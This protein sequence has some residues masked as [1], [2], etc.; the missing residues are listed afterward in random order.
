MG[1]FLS[2]FRGGSD[3]SGD[4]RVSK[5]TCDLLDSSRLSIFSSGLDLVRVLAAR[6]DSV[7]LFALIRT[8]S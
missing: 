6:C 5:S 7:C 8:R 4:L 1:C 3:P 2:C